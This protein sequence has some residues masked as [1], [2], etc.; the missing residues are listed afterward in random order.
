MLNMRLLLNPTGLYRNRTHQRGQRSGR[1]TSTTFPKL[2]QL[3]AMPWQIDRLGTGDVQ[4]SAWGE[5]MLKPFV[6]S[7]DLTNWGVN[8]V[9]NMVNHIVLRLTA[10]NQMEQLPRHEGPKEGTGIVQQAQALMERR[11]AGEDIL[12]VA[13][14]K[15]AEVTI[16]LNTLFQ[17]GTYQ[18]TASRKWHHR[19]HELPHLVELPG[20]IQELMQERGIARDEAHLL[21]IFSAFGIGQRGERPVEALHSSPRFHG[22]RRFDFAAIAGDDGGIVRSRW[23]MRADLIFTL[24][25]SNSGAPDAKCIFGPVYNVVRGGQHDYPWEGDE[26]YASA[27]LKLASARREKV[28]SGYLDGC[29]SAVPIQALKGRVVVLPDYESEGQT[30]GVIFKDPSAIGFQ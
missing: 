2:T 27:R 23:V 5:E 19:L 6:A 29:Y 1:I 12:D 8:L 25:R 17:A 28:A 10:D 30:D 24:A 7:K 21:H 26:E 18:A 9:E 3:L 20:A 15:T 14:P 4:T 16:S 22:R 13:L 11:A